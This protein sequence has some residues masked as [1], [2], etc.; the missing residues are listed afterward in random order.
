MLGAMTTEITLENIEHYRGHLTI[1]RGDL[2]YDKWE[3]FNRASFDALKP[4]ARA[5]VSLREIVSTKN[6]L[7]D[8]KF[9]AGQ[10]P[11]PRLTAFIKMCEAGQGKGSPRDPIVVRKDSRGKYL[12][13]DGN[14]TAQVLML[15][16]W[17]EMPVEI[18]GEN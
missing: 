14:A 13:L 15:V 7:Q 12:V 6:Q 10:K 4:E 18:S 8:E 3:L 9:L 11:D 17:V 5:L 16:G 2:P 1:K